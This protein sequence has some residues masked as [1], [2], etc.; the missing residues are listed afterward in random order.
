M[1]IHLQHTAL[2]S[3]AVVGAI[4]LSCLTFLTEPKLPIGLDGEGRRRR[5]R[6]EG[7][8]SRVAHAIRRAPGIGKDRCGVAPVEHRIENETT[9][10]GAGP[11]H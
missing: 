1:V 4:R 9:D 11:Y 3:R 7:G 10:G 6:G 8:Q 5:R 2:A